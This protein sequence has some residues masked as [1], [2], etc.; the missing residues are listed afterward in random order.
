[1]VELTALLDYCERVLECG[2]FK[3]Y[4]PNG[5][6]LEAGSR[7]QRICCGVTASQ[8]LIDHAVAIKAD[9]L[10]VHHGFFWRGENPAITGVKAKRLATL[11]KHDINLIAYHLPLDAHPQLGNNA[12]LA[13]RFGFEVDGFFGRPGET[14][15]AMYGCLS[16]AMDSSRF[17]EHVANALDRQPLYIASAPNKK[18]ERVAWC[19][20]GAQS[21]FDLAIDLGVDAFITGEASEQNYH[22][23]L[24]HGVDFI[25]AGHHATERY[26]VQALAEHLSQHFGLEYEYY[27]MSNPI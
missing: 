2:K 1:M 12:Q 25:A 18:I 4:C 27:E 5:L 11:M 23:A 8:A 13:K 26:G 21:Y 7:V 22:Q 3:D 10:L 15:I 6:Q 24:E 20:G 14:E 17:A 16:D 19:S 9:V